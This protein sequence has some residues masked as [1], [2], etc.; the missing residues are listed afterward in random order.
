MKINILMLD[1]ILFFVIIYI[2]TL[3][4]KD[5]KIELF[6]ECPLEM[7]G[8]KGDNGNNGRN[9]E[10]IYN[11]NKLISFLKRIRKGHNGTFYLN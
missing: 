5:T 7:K 9:G 1:I 2:S 11:N 6:Q 4:F 8:E 10:V 3:L